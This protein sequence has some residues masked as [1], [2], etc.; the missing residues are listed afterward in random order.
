MAVRLDPFKRIVNV[1]WG[2][3]PFS[4]RIHI[5][6]LA[7]VNTGSIEFPFFVSANQYFRLY[8]KKP[9][10][11]IIEQI[12][13]DFHMVQANG[14][15]SD[16]SPPYDFITGEVPHDTKFQMFSFVQFPFGPNEPD[17]SEKFSI[18]LIL[19]SKSGNELATSHVLSMVPKS[20]PDGVA[21]TFDGAYRVAK[22]PIGVTFGSAPHVSIGIGA[23]IKYGP[24]HEGS[25]RV[26]PD[27]Y[28]IEF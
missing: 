9:P 5:Q 4:L 24:D 10:D 23:A 14:D 6:P 26:P 3:G 15:T 8:Q 17:N 18:D 12:G 19:L 2:S 7:I 20:Y 22:M 28:D 27:P 16:F 13:G 1:S 21:A 25:D 11:N